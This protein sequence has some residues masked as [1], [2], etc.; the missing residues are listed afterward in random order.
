MGA[1]PEKVTWQGS[2][3][4]HLLVTQVSLPGTHNSLALHG[5]DLA[6]C[7]SKSLEQQLALGI[8]FFD[9]RVKLKHHRLLMYHGIA[10]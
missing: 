8:R 10:Y 5:T 9:L 3:P 1:D 6:R 2:L 4:D 7:Q